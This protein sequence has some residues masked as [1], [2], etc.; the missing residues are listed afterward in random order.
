MKGVFIFRNLLPESAV[1]QLRKRCLRYFG[2]HGF[3]D[4]NAPLMEGVGAQDFA[5]L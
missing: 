5:I 2:K 3:L 1:L 4:E